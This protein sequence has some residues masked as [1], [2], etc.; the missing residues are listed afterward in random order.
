MLSQ[1]PLQ[2]LLQFMLLCCS[3][4]ITQNFEDV[5]LRFID[6]I[7]QFNKTYRYDVDEY[8]RRFIPFQVSDKKKFKIFVWMK[9]QAQ[10]NLYCLTIK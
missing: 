1:R 2:V 6:Y 10:Q 3:K 4:I 5:E 8:R 9:L 7:V